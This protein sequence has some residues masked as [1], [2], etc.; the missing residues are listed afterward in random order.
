MIISLI[1]VLLSPFASGNPDGLERVAE[2]LGFL[3]TGQAPAYKILPDYTVP[4]LGKTPIST[5]AA[6]VIGLIVVGVI[7][8]LLGQKMKAKS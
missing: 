5:I 4:F 1:V 7:L 8:V 6:G 2:D 3:G